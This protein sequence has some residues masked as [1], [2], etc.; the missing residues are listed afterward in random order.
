MEQANDELHVDDPAVEDESDHQSDDDTDNS[1][2]EQMTFQNIIAVL[3]G[4][5]S[6]G[7]LR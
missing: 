6:L 2:D 4:R 1:D 7:G 3:V 5:Q